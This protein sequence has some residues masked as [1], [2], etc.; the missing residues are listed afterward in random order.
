MG[1]GLLIASL[2]PVCILLLAVN[3]QNFIKKPKEQKMEHR[4][5]INEVNAD[6]PGE[7]TSEYVELY[8]TSGQQVP[9]DGYSLVFYNGRGNMAYKVMDLKD[10]STNNQGFLLIGSSTV[11]PRPAVIIPRN[12]IQNGP[13]AIALYYGRLDLYEKMNVTSEGLVDA[14]VHKSKEND[15]ADE[16]VSVLTPGVEP[17]LED[18]FFRTMDESLERCHGTDYSQLFFQVGA[19]TP[20]LDNH[21]IPFSQLNASVV[22]INEVKVTSSPGEC[23][24]IE[25]QGPPSTEVKDLVLVL[26]EGT[27][28]EIYFIMEVHGK[29]SLDGLL[30]LGT[31]QSRIPV[32][33]TFPPN[34]SS[35]LFRTG[36]N[37]IALYRGSNGS[38]ALRA[39]ATATNLLDALVY[40][41][42]EG[43]D[44]KLRDVLTPGKPL[45]YVRERSHQ[46][47]TSVNRCVCCSTTRDSSAYS[48]GNPTPR[49]FNDCPKRRFGQEISLCLQA[50]DCQ[51][52]ILEKSQIQISLSQVLDKRCNCG[53]SPIYFKDPAVT[54][55]GM[56][57]VFTAVLTARSAEQLTKLLQAFSIAL[58]SEEVMNFG[59]WNSTVRKACPSHANMTET[60]PALTSESPRMTTAPPIPPM[61]LLINEVNP[62][63]PGSREDMEYIELFYPGQV[64]FELRDYWLVLYNGKNNLAY[65]VIDLSGHSTDARGYFLV[66]SARVTPKPSIV[67]RDNTIQNGVEAVA[68]YHGPRDAFKMNTPLTSK[69]LVDAVV[70]KARG[71]ENPDKLLAVL[72]P[73]QSILYENDSHSTEDESLSRCFSLRPRNQSSF[74]MTELTPF[75]ENAC[76]P[77]GSNST[78]ETPH[79]HSVV[80][81]EL[82]MANTSIV[83]RFIELKGKPGTSLEGYRLVFFAKPNVVP[84]A[85]IQLEG[86]F[87]SNGL[88]LLLPE[89]Q[90]RPGEAHEQMVTP[91]WSHLPSQLGIQVVALFSPRTQF[92]NQL[93]TTAK[94][95]EDTVAYAWQPSAI[96]GHLGFL[97]TVHFI[98]QKGKRPFSLSRCPSCKETFA[99]SDPTPGL[100][101]SCPRDSLSVDLGMCLQT[102]NCSMWRWN[103]TI[104]ANLR[105]ALAA[106]MEQSCLCSISP[107]YLQGLNF[108][109]LN[110]TLKLSG[111]VWARSPEQQ[112]LLI[113]WR[114]SFS[115]SPHL[116]IVDGR[117]LKANATCFPPDVTV[118]KFE[119]SFQAWQIALTILGSVLLVLLLAGAAFYWI[120]RR[121]QNYSNIEL[122]D[123]CEIMA[124]M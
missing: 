57:L 95:V 120:K 73:G 113:K 32:D 67:L 94:N 123:R 5:L 40:T 115:V 107:C 35:P 42:M 9:L 105:Q 14:L 13:D 12:T 50:P 26:I 69:G 86:T 99:V 85:N 74:Q 118:L 109:C 61:E 62:D 41:T 64:P 72:T 6:N 51:Q 46:N 7:D 110:S 101:N 55:N 91:L 33:L 17:F 114:S 16:L 23:E 29:T 54:C 22:L 11:V 19:P 21:C 70:Y 102:P 124:D 10:F 60:T 27:T 68:L 90:S 37:A 79:Q 18:P 39:A 89:G 52:E 104:L 2:L 84:Y 97:E 96:Q 65:S 48:L 75:R 25:L 80:I 15:R 78:G 121:P 77:L 36:T 98:S 81:N 66:G 117:P 4:L 45:F 103:P 111:Q 34:S 71:S 83:H 53:I 100:Q 76:P 87:G 49:Q 56:E 38:F 58:E 3:S 106:S 28:Q 93:L 44:L 47:D 112:Q 59:K 88:F 116:F 92:P 20:G 119:A 8:H 82:D 1:P 63:N 24:F 122:N 43:T 108:T 31:D 30:L